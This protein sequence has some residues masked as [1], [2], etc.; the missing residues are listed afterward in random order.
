[1]VEEDIYGETEVVI[2]RENKKREE[3]MTRAASI[4]V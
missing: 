1:V 2:T 4:M 3:K